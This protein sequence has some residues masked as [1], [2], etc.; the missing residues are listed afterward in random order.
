MSRQSIS[1]LTL[2]FTAAGVITAGR[3]VAPGGTQATA[4]ANTLG[5]SRQDAVAN[6]KATVEVL[7]TSAV[8]T[9]GAISVNDTL[10]SDSVGRAITWSSSGAK[11]GLA[12]E[13]A[14]AAG[15]TIEVLLIPN[16][17]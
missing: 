10:K 15:Q 12:L 8:E 13:A 11:I 14:T 3:F 17:A 5:V 2:S 6:D 1:V 9:G 4:G 16:V 7:G